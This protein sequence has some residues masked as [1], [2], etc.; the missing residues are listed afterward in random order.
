M[1][2]C[3]KVLLFIFF[4]LISC[5]LPGPYRDIEIRF[6]NVDHATVRFFKADSTIPAIEHFDRNYCDRL[7]IGYLDDGY[8]RIEVEAKAKQRRII[9]DSL[10]HYKE[11]FTWEVEF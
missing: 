5:E 3:S 10:I 6:T 1:K 4:C 2:A 9:K 7:N 11:R 8:L